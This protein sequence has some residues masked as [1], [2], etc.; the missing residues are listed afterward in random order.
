MA[1]STV[2]SLT[3]IPNLAAGIAAAFDTSPKMDEFILQ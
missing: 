1:L 2:S 3:W